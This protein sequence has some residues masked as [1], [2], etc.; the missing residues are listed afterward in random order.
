MP[1]LPDNFSLP[2]KITGTNNPTD[3]TSI[4]ANSLDIKSGTA[5]DGSKDSND[6]MISSE[7]AAKNNLKVGDT[8][9]AYKT[10][11]TVAA[12][13]ESNTQSGNSTVIVSLPTEQRLANKAGLVSNGVA[14]IDSLEN[15]ESATSA[16]KNALGSSADITSN[17]EQA[18][19]ALDPLNSVRTVT[20]Y[21]LIG[22]VAAGA[23]I[24]LLA[25]IM[26][27][28]ERRREI[29]ILKAIGG[30]NI[31]I[32]LQF[33]SEAL[34]FTILGAVVGLII[35]IAGSSPVTSTLV[36]NSGNT[37]N[38]SSETSVSTRYDNPLLN[39][40]KDIQAEV[41]W[42][43]ILYGLGAAVLIA[44]IGSALASYSVSKVRPAEVLRS[45]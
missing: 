11:I 29:G 14:T 10:T 19:Q 3:P 24:I 22:A 18:K 9:T 16:I 13:F 25:M 20:L 35:G 4:G 45:E 26:I 39:N 38:A 30:S 2:I 7:M 12:I 40:V 17:L 42:S 33:M 6:A 41:G 32:M 37:G 5:I 1:T 34:T 43:I 8:F 23:I 36:R 44:L 28:R 15:L 27:V 21:S 31:R